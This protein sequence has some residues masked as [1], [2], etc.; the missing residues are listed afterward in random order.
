MTHYAWSNCPSAVREQIVHLLKAFQN[1]LHDN[2]VA[3]Y[4]HGSLAMG[5]FHPDH[6]DIDLLVV[7]QHG[8]NVETKRQLAELLLSTS[9]WPCPIEISFV[10][11]PALHPFRHPLPYDFHYS[12]YWRERLSQ[13]LA[14]E[15][16]K[17]W[18]DNQRYDTDLT[19]HLMVISRRGVCL[20]GRPAS[21]TLPTVPSADFA[22]TIVGDFHEASKEPGKNPVYFVL[23]ACRILAFLREEHIFSKDEGGSWGLQNLPEDWQSIVVQALEVYRGSSKEAAFDDAK[24]QAFSVYMKRNIHMLFPGERQTS[25]SDHE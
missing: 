14:D 4:L 2:L 8:M 13:Q 22:R 19:A 3:I 5:C 1:I 11:M 25:S 7:T 21:E 23:N 16:W 24:L 15:T 12:E 18:N 10:V 6:S 17:T 20:Y 9:Q